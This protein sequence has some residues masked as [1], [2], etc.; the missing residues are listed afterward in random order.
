MH[1]SLPSLDQLQHHPVDACSQ[2]C[3]DAT[4]FTGALRADPVGQLPEE[5]WNALQ[6]I[7]DFVSI[8]AAVA[9]PPRTSRSPLPI[10]LR[11]H[12][13][14]GQSASWQR[15]LEDV[16]KV[17]V[18]VYEQLS[19]VPP[20]FAPPCTTRCS[21]YDQLDLSPYRILLGCLHMVVLVS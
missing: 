19:E 12:F 3:K 13:T 15:S 17:A 21:S 16:S 6:P 10:T 8:S 14:A 20:T 18:G 9:G 2:G 11:I 7:L 4:L 5:L 1:R